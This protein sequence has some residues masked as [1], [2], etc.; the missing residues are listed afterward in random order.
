M[1][2]VYQAWCMCIKHGAC[3]SSMVHMYLSPLSHSVQFGPMQPVPWHSVQ[4]SAACA[5]QAKQ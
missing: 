3:V 5:A 4:R 2:H 1:V